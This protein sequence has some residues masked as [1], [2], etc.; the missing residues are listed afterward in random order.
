[1]RAGQPDEGGQASRR[2]SEA[3]GAPGRLQSRRRSRRRPPHVR[4]PLVERVVGGDVRRVRGVPARTR[5]A[6]ALLA[7]LESGVLRAH[8]GEGGW[9]VWNRLERP[10]LASGSEPA[11]IR[12]GSAWFWGQHASASLNPAF[13]SNVIW[14]HSA[15]GVQAG[16]G[17]AAHQLS[18][19]RPPP[20]GWSARRA[21]A[22]VEDSSQPPPHLPR[23]SAGGQ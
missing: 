4:G 12:G 2:G 1:M 13:R 5:A 19:S 17:R 16:G 10:V 9:A 18:S 11:H 8:G 15:H 21:R 3:L 20:G 23:T 6:S 7:G 14:A 22:A